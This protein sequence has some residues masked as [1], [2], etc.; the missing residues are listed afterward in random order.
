[1]AAIGDQLVV[2][3]PAQQEDRVR[4]AP[5]RS[6]RD[7]APE[8][9]EV[10]DLA[11][12]APTDARDLTRVLLVRLAALE[13]GTREYSYVRSSLVELNLSLVRFALRRFGSHR[14]NTEDLMQVGAVGLIKAIDRFDPERGVEFTTFAIPTILGELRRHFRDTTWAVH[15]PRRLQ[16]LRLSL[17]KAQDALSQSLDRAP[18]VAELAEYLSI[19]QEEVVEGM[20]AANAHSTDSLDVPAGPDE[21]GPGAIAARIGGVDER[22]GMVEDLVSLQPLVA[23]LPER[24]R[25]ILS[26]RFTQEMTQSQIGERLGLSQMHVSRLLSRTLKQLR[27]GLEGR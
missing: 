21:D 6:P 24:D 8:L 18:T 3:A 19:S 2:T 9:A 27:A 7:A 17:A 14:E 25:L 13:E 15:V 1:M 23:A 5:P 20:T 4:V 11:E 10:G 22:L 16:E 12:V 26:M